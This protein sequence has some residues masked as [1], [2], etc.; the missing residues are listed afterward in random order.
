NKVFT[1]YFGSDG[2]VFNDEE[3]VITLKYRVFGGVGYD[4]QLGLNYLYFN[5]IP[6]LDKSFAKVTIQNYFPQGF[7]FNE[8]YFRVFQP[9]LSTSILYNHSYDPSQRMLQITLD[10]FFTDVDF[11]Y[12]VGM[13]GVNPSTEV[14]SKPAVVHIAHSTPE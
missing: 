10:D 6:K 14:I 3:F 9:A 12:E 1:Y 13:T 2:R 5:A 7:V 4:E 11:T 8:K